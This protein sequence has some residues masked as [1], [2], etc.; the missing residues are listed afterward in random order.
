M[1]MTDA[2]G[3][4][5]ETAADRVMVDFLVKSCSWLVVGVL[6]KNGAL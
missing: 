1:L 2:I 4:S 5:A 6:F 3:V